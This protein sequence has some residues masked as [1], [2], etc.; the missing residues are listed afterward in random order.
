MAKM[1]GDTRVKR[2]LAPTF[3]DIKRKESQFVLRVKPG[4]HSKKRAYPVGIILRDI[5]KVTNTMRESEKIVNE[6]KVKVD[7]VIRRDINFS[8]GL[9]DVIEL[10]PTGQAYRLVPKDSK[11]LVPIVINENE[12]TL[13]LIKIISK[14]LIKGNKLQYGFHDGK[15]VISDRVMM[16]GDT[17]LVH[18]PS[19]EINSHIKFEEGAVILITSGE[20]AG[21]IG[22]VHTIR[23][24][25]FSLPRRVI[26][27]FEDRSVELPVGIVMAVGADKPIIKVN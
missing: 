15:C 18:L 14:V 25:I 9:M 11:L 3:W 19:V 13:K 10:V 1:G 17:C 21:S 20:N 5:L 22:K 12:K 7:G 26:V 16:V 27:S 8:V 24:G 4:P 2:Q 6:G 23:D